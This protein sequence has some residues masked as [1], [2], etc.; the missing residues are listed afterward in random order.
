MRV[1]LLHVRAGDGG[2]DLAGDQGTGERAGC[3]VSLVDLLDDVDRRRLGFPAAG[4]VRIRCDSAIDQPHSSIHRPNGLA[5]CGA[6]NTDLTCSRGVRPHRR[7]DVDRAGWRRS[8]GGNFYGTTVGEYLYP[9]SFVQTGDSGSV[10]RMTASGA[11]TVLHNFT[12]SLRSFGASPLG[13]VVQAPD[14]NFYRT[15]V[16]GEQTNLAPYSA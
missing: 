8:A 3:G 16:A 6:G 9:P 10:F 14:G 12:Q 4:V 13:H 15:T 7:P 11:M 5:D 2:R 1:K